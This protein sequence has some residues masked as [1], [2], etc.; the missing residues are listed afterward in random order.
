MIIVMKPGASAEVLKHVQDRVREAGM[1]P[2]TICGTERQVVAAVGDERHITTEFFR[3]CP[4]VDK[5]MPVLDPYKLA[6]AERRK[7]PSVIE[8]PNGEKVGGV[9]IGVI[10]G[11]CTVEDRSMLIDTAHAVKEAG[12]MALRGGAFKPRTDPYTF[13]GLEEKALIYLADAREE[14][15]L[16]VVTEVM[17]PL[18]VKL[19]SKYADILQVGTRNMQ[20]F[21]LLDA[22]GESE[23]PVLLKRG[24]SATIDEWILAGEYI[25]RQGNENVML[26][27]R[28]IRTYEKAVRNTL[29]LVAV[30]L[31]KSR[32]H[33]P[34]VVDP[35]HGTGKSSLVPAASKGAV[36]MGADALI[37]EVHP[38]PENAILD[39]GQSLDLKQFA[40]LMKDIRAV[41]EAVGRT[42]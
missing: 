12:A 14:T 25:L 13:R 30:P 21:M 3:V 2:H 23:K 29:A 8:L 15:G 17:T 1:E 31:L 27:E 34:V 33:L 41:A 6:S 42:A 24:M 7:E 38:D 37:V 35:S 36:A 39:G 5:V 19:I 16:P 18:D 4:G 9:K 22:C 20:N 11:P 40:G 10:A 26:C 32:T 28:G